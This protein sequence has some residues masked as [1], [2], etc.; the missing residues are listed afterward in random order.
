MIHCLVDSNGTEFEVIATYGLHTIEDRKG[1]WTAVDTLS[2][3]VKHLWLMMG[4]FN[5]ILRG[6][7]KIRCQALDSETRDFE[8]CLINNG[9]T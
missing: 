5:A 8:Q 1:L 9:L 7:C 2:Q 4:D 3:M 6:K